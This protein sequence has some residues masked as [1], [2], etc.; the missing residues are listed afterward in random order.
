MVLGPSAKDKNSLSG[1]D[2][3]EP[4]S[5]TKRK[6]D[7]WDS[8]PS[9]DSLASKKARS[10]SHASCPD[11]SDSLPCQG[12][13][14]DGSHREQADEDEDSAPRMVKA[15]VLSQVEW[16]QAKQEGSCLLR[17]FKPG[18]MELAAVTRVGYSYQ[19]VGRIGF[20]K[21]EDVTKHTIQGLH[22]RCS[23]IYSHREVSRMRLS[24]KWLWL[25]EVNHCQPVSEPV[26]LPWLDTKFRNRVFKLNLQD[27]SQT[28]SKKVSVPSKLEIGETA[29]Y[30]FDRWPQGRQ[31]LLWDRLAHF[32][33]KRLRLGTTCSGSD[34]CI[35]VVKQAI[36]HFARQKARLLTLETHAYIPKVHTSIDISVYI[37][38]YVCM[39][40]FK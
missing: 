12:V 34:V 25:C 26:D 19:Y 28:P 1:T 8:Y 31:K 27:Q 30:M 40:I 22:F 7:S 39:Y 18:Q 3:S 21:L 32:H 4:S 20:K 15:I 16:Q 38:M 35:A 29:Q 24:S 33:S 13:P 9:S 37:Y 14:V 6:Q 5:S 23:N 17:A 36:E 2:S 10:S 11:S